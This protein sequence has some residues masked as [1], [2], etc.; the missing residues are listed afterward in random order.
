MDIANNITTQDRTLHFKL[1]KNEEKKKKKKK[2]LT[3]K[4]TYYVILFIHLFFIDKSL[5]NS[6]IC[7]SQYYEGSHD[8]VWKPEIADFIPYNKIG[9]ITTS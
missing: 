4:L 9:T 6:P 8:T 3:K 2:K 5:I 7:S 1:E